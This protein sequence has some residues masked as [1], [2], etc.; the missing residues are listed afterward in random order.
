MFTFAKYLTPEEAK[1]QDDS[2]E[3]GR[4]KPLQY[5]KELAKNNSM[6]E[7]CGVNPVWKLVDTGTCFA[8]TTGEADAS[9]DYELI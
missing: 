2:L 5:Y 8:C 4:R 9:N 6:C 3:G 7:V 1:K